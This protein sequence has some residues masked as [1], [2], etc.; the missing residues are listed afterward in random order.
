MK[1]F[2]KQFYAT[3]TPSPESTLPQ[4]TR[5]SLVHV[6]LANLYIL[7]VRRFYRKNLNYKGKISGPKNSVARGVF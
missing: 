6:F 2:L 1:S 4:A 5:S 7:K 3:I